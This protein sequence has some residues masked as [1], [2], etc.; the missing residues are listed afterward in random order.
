MNLG[1]EIAAKP[2]LLFL[3]EPTSGLDA[4]AATIV[5]TALKALSRYG[6]G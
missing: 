5:L 4:T 3:D 2:G 6:E 1:V